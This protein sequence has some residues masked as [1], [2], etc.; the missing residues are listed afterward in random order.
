MGLLE[1]A[2]RETEIPSSGSGRSS[3]YA[4]AI[5][6]TSSTASPESRAK[7]VPERLPQPSPPRRATSSL[8]F[9]PEAL[10]S[11][12]SELSA[13]SPTHDAYLAS[14]SKASSILRLSSFALFMPRGDSLVPVARIGFP[15]KP[16]AAVPSL[17]AEHAQGGRDPLDQTASDAL[18]AALGATPSL[19][20]RA[21]AMHSGSRITAL[22]VYRD[23]ALETSPRD[24]QSRLGATL[25]S[26]SRR[27]A[28]LVHILGASTKPERVLLDSVSHSARAS[29]F[30]FDLS[31]L[32]GEISASC[33]GIST[34]LLLSSFA[35]ACSSILSGEGAAAPCGPSRIGCALGSSSSTDHELALFQFG[36]SLKRLL[37]FLSVASFPSGRSASIATSSAD[38]ASELARFLAS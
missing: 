35:A 33:P 11:L 31:R 21:A 30:L 2:I 20:L 27:G 15:Q 28:P 25:S 36:K 6:A 22:W 24:L 13:I 34:E 19:P 5:A 12:E 38:A 23:A 32:Y 9:T 37:P 18:S 4:K 16:I 3:L 26:M 8:A 10:S 29:L 7:A 17:T 1:K 14:W